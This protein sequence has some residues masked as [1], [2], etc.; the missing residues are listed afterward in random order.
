MMLLALQR[1]YQY[2][3]KGDKPIGEDAVG[4]VLD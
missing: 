2:R 1:F 4:G 3:E